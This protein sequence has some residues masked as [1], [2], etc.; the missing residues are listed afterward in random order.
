VRRARTRDQ[1]LGGDATTVDA[2]PA[3]KMAL[4]YRHLAA[5]IAQADGERWARLAG[6]YDDG[7]ETLLH[8]M[9]LGGA[10]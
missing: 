8:A 1:R 5:R 3:D 4:D 6:A 2:G 10:P 9:L 7:I